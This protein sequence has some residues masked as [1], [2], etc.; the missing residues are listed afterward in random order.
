MGS[1]S[2]GG[3]SAL[4]KPSDTV[5]H[6][7]SATN[8]KRTHGEEVPVLKPHRARGLPIM[9]KRELLPV[10]FSSWLA[11]YDGMPYARVVYTIPDAA[12]KAYASS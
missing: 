9:P 8:Y 6:V 5:R 1:N 11:E 2:V 12:A 3:Q 4:S 10:P 7:E